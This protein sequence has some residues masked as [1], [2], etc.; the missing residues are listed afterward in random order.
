MNEIYLDGLSASKTLDNPKLNGKTG[1]KK[2]PVSNGFLVTG[3]ELLNKKQDKLK[4]LVEGLLPETGVVA[5]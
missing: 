4:Y 5:L 2:K 3:E 1:S